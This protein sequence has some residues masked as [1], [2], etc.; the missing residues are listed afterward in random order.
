MITSLCLLLI[1]YLHAE[2]EERMMPSGK[3]AAATALCA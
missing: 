2:T 3:A 1:F